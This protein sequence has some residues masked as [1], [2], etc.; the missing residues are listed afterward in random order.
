MADLTRLYQILKEKHLKFQYRNYCKDIL[1]YLKKQC[2]S[3]VF[4]FQ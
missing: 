2:Q 1:E 4:R 3:I